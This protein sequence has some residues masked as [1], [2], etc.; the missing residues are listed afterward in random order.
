MFS[1]LVIKTT[2]LLTGYFF[3]IL[4]K[5][6]LFY[7]EYYMEIITEGLNTLHE[8]DRNDK[9]YVVNFSTLLLGD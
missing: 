5:I 8:K 2:L 9:S 6:S 3:V 4:K 7:R 1:N